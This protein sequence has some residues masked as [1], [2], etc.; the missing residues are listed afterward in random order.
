MFFIWPSLF[1]FQAFFDIYLTLS[2]LSN[3]LPLSSLYLEFNPL[4][5]LFYFT[6]DGNLPREALGNNVAARPFSAEKL[7][8]NK[9][10]GP[11]VRI[12]RIR[13]I[14]RLVLPFDFPNQCP[15][16]TPSPYSACLKQLTAR[17]K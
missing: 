14:L 17:H 16:G 11:K 6:L 10:V 3:S 4:E 7:D 9:S 5:S 1:R 12:S 2:L 13:L 15:M 8:L